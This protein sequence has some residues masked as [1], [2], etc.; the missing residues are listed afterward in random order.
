MRLI[1]V[2]VLSPVADP[3]AVA[4]PNRLPWGTLKVEVASARSD[5]PVNDTEQLQGHVPCV[6]GDKPLSCVRIR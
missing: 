1:V 6:D 2:T 5:D 3:G 4:C